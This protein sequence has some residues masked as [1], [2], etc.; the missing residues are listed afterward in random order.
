MRTSTVAPAYKKVTMITSTHILTLSSLRWTGLH[1]LLSWI[2]KLNHNFFYWQ[3]FFTCLPPQKPPEI[4]FT[5]SVLEHVQRWQV[6]WIRY[7]VELKKKQ[8]KTAI[9]SWHSPFKYS[10]WWSRHRHV[11]LSSV[12]PVYN[13]INQMTVVLVGSVSIERRDQ[14]GWGPQNS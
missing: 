2:N 11:L 12:H 5:P 13:C 14:F 3:F 1:F 7:I 4:A 6:S 10:C 8:K 9:P